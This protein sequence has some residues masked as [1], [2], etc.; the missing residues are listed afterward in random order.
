MKI[1]LLVSLTVHQSSLTQP[2]KVKILYKC[3]WRILWE[4]KSDNSKYVSSCI[5]FTAVND[6]Y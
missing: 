3:V 4:S 6:E 5:L 1:K 2:R